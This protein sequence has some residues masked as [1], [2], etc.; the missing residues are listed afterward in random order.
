M[1]QMVP[2]WLNLVA[3]HKSMQMDAFLS[4][5]NSEWVKGLNLRSDTLY[6]I[7]EEVGKS[8]EPIATENDKADIPALRRSSVGV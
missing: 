8:L 1:E 6:L 3:A 5:C 4:T 7:E 2:C